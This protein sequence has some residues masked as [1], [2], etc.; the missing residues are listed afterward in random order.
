MKLPPE[1]GES[2]FNMSALERAF[3]GAA[4][5]KDE[6]V[7]VLKWIE[8]KMMSKFDPIFTS[9]K[10]ALDKKILSI[11]KE[12]SVPQ[13]AGVTDYAPSKDQKELLKFYANQRKLRL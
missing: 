4:R 3:E 1:M 10:E 6:W 8:K 7:K 5:K 13:V 12:V 11:Y 9:D 2:R